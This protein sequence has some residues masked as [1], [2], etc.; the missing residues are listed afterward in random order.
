MIRGVV[1]ALEWGYY[2]AAAI[3]GYTI[4]RDKDAGVVWASGTIVAADAFK[5]T[6][7]PLMFV[8]LVKGGE[9]R[10]PL[11]EPIPALGVGPFT[12]RLGPQERSAYVVPSRPS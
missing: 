6:Q 8:A 7:R 9:W 4:A 2:R 1:A 5:C 10:W 11:L 3:E 12:V